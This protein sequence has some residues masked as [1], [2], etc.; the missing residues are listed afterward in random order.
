MSFELVEY[1]HPKVGFTLPFP[2]DWEQRTDPYEGVALVAVIPEEDYGFR[3]N[4]VVT[5]DEVPEM[6]LAVW[7][8]SAEQLLQQGLVEFV[9]LDEEYVELGGRTAVR[10]L[11]HHTVGEDAVTMEQ[12]AFLDQGVGYTL[13]ASA[14]TWVYDHVAELLTA[15][16]DGFRPS[17]PVAS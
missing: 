11:G 10:R 14:D 6:D 9:L 17:G 15:I 7:Q 13:T 5:L 8:F 12:W 1:Q 16:T 4:V 2:P 3:T